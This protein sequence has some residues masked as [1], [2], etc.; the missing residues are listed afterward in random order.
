[1]NITATLIGQMLTFAIFVWFTMK[2]VWPPL[3]KAL[4]DR[5]DKIADGL[6]AAERG[7]QELSLAQQ[8]ATQTIRESKDQAAEIIDHAN[9]R[10]GQLIEEAKI[11]ARE[12]AK[13]IGQ[14]AQAEIDQ[15]VNHAR[16]ALR[17]QV[18]AIAISGAEKILAHKIDE[19]ANNEIL[20]KLV[21]EI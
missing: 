12:E 18:A 5:Q 7:R 16:E 19:A 3:S 9:L 1:M 13:Y 21:G 6:A 15:K 10:A 2:F 20:E 8:R 4:Q 14:Q 11:K 17:K